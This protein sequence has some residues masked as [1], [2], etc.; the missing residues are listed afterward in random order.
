[1]TVTITMVDQFIQPAGAELSQVLLTHALSSNKGLPDLLVSQK[2]FQSH[3]LLHLFFSAMFLHFFCFFCDDFPPFPFNFQLSCSS[4]Y[5]AVERYFNQKINPDFQAS[6]YCRH[7]QFVQIIN[8]NN[9]THNYALIIDCNNILQLGI[10]NIF[11]RQELL[12]IF[13]L[14]VSDMIS[15][16]DLLIY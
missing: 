8:I 11:F 2:T 15:D 3:P 13:I 5:G 10:F 1:M 16:F 6:L 9:K 12:N 14:S 4:S 7:M